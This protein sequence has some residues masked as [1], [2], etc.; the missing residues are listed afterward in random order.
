[1]ETNE[2][3]ACAAAPHTLVGTQPRQNNYPFTENVGAISE[4]GPR[5]SV[6]CHRKHA[7]LSHTGELG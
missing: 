7:D 1:M 2:R 3:L 5:T 6:N 4:G